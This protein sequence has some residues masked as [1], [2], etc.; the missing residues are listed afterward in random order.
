MKKKLLGLFFILTMSIFAND[1][2]QYIQGKVL[3]EIKYEKIEKD[4]MLTG[5]TDYSVEIKEGEHKG[6]VV[7]IS[8]GTYKEEQYNIDVKPKMKVVLYKGADGYY[9]VE[10][11][12]RV[13]IYILGFIFLGLTLIITRKQGLKALL[14]LGITGVL[15]FKWMVPMIISGHSPILLAVIISGICSVVTIFFMAGITRKGI[16][17]ILGTLGGVIVSGILSLIFSKHMGL[18]GYISMDSINYATIVK[19]IDLK[20]LVSA[21]IIIGSTG[22]I[23]DV[24]ISISSALE[25]I[26]LHKP[27]IESIDLFKSGMRIGNDIIGTM[28]N[29]LI[30]AYI[31]SSLFTIMILTIQQGDYPAIRLFNF[32]FVAVEFLKAFCGSIGIVV[33]VPL[34]SFLES[35][36]FR[37]KRKEELEIN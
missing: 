13:E 17:G 27:N 35:K 37:N 11:D 22:A 1:K 23:M 5:M 28:I 9:I 16:L 7:T 31:G 8:Q 12:R 30:L 10:K 14:S 32:E 19:G 2:D 15:I 24:A 25:E 6:E 21:G 20:Q 26:K 4:D 33:C 3:R 18:T 36:L 29:T 34:T